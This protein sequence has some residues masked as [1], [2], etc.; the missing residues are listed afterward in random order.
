MSEIAV[1]NA[2]MTITS[3]D[4]YGQELFI[5]KRE[6]LSLDDHYVKAFIEYPKN[7]SLAYVK[8]CD[9]MGLYVD[10]R[11][12]RQYAHAIHN[13]LLDRIDKELQALTVDDKAYGRSVTRHLAGKAKSEQVRAQTARTLTGAHYSGDN[14]QASGVEVTVNRDNVTIKHNNS[15]LTVNKDKNIKDI[16]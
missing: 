1:D 8:A 5:E 13:R 14:T 9:E 2:A 7:K 15:T 11:Y 12:V 16:D 10:T 4:E 3:V 6:P